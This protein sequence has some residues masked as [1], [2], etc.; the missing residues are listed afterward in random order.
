MTSKIANKPVTAAPASMNLTALRIVT[1]RPGSSGE[2]PD[3]FVSMLAK[4]VPPPVDSLNM[5][6]PNVN[7]LTVE[8]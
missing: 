4:A 1:G 7:A 6:C 2:P 3:S 5:G 8:A